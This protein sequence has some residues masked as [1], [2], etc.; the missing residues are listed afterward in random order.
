MRVREGSRIA[1]AR[2]DTEIALE[3]RMV[4]AIARAFAARHG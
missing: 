4:Y 2:Q 3:I 1:A